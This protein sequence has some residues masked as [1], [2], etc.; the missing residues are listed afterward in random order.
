MADDFVTVN[1]TKALGN[2]VGRLADLLREMREL[3]DKLMDAA[4]HSK[5]LK[6]KWLCP[7]CHAARHKELGRLRTVFTMYGD[8][9]EPF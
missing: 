1:R 7:V 5:P 6:V 9:P 3:T 8:Q 4:D 2:S